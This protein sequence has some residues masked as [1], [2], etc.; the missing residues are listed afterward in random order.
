MKFSNCTNVTVR[1]KT[2][3]AGK[4]NCVDAVR[5]ANYR[6]GGCTFKDGA[7]VSTFTLKGSID[8]WLI[9][10]CVVG[11]GK[12]TDIELGQFDNYWYIGRPPTRNGI[13][14]DSS[15]TYGKPIRITCWNAEP[16][17]IVDTDVKITKIPA[18]VW[19]P[20]FCVRWITI[21]I[22]NKFLK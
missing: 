7:G 5:G 11:H 2:V 12:N 14:R 10:E 21:R 8:G 15:S 13:I 18:I 17:K 16:P 9:D 19:F 4:E 1:D 3:E 22:T 6:W 20:Y